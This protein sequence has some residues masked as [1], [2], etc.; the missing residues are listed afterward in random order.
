[1]KA[2]DGRPSFPTSIGLTNNAGDEQ[3]LR[4]I[5]LGN[6]M[7]WSPDEDIDFVADGGS[8]N[9]R[10]G[11]KT[12]TAALIAQHTKITRSWRSP[13]KNCQP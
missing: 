5:A 7:G 11:P 4:G 2:F 1:L 8:A 9:H 12:Q 6:E 13:V 10:D 3:A